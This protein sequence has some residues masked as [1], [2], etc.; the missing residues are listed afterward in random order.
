M[1]STHRIRTQRQKI[2]DTNIFRSKKIIILL[3][4][5]LFSCK[6]TS[7]SLPDTPKGGLFTLNSIKGA[8]SLSNYKGKIVLTY[9]GFLSCPDVCPN[10][11][12]VYS[13]VFHDMK[14]EELN[15]VEFLF[16]DVDPNRD[17]LESIQEYVNAFHEKFTAL[18][19]QEEELK[20]I[21][22]QYGASFR[23]VPIDSAMEYTIDHSTGVYVLNSEGKILGV[24][25]HGLTKMETK[26]KLE[27]F[28]KDI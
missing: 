7:I 3:L 13:S 10:T 18:S 1:E 16:I 26:K 23:K 9:F 24:I 8:V 21:A 12:Q 22:A 19:G 28:L 14:Q 15:R 5:F 27:G 11:L 6:P 25:A 2:W 17:S 4:V 20:K